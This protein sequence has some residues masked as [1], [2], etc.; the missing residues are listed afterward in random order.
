[1]KRIIAALAAI[2]AVL[3]AV[4]IC[5]L[6]TQQE[7]Q[8][9]LPAGTTAVAQTTAPAETTIPTEPPTEAP[10]EP[11]FVAEKTE[12]SDPEKWGSTWTIMANGEVVE[13]YE[14]E[15]KISFETGDYF[16]LP[17]V[18]SFRG[19][20]YRSDP[21]YGVGDIVSGKIKKLSQMNVYFISDP[22]WMGCGWTGQPLV[23][24][25][26][27]QTR[28][29]MN[30]HDSK[31][32]K[33]GL[34]EVIYAKM[35]GYIHFFDMED[36]SETRDPIYLGMI[37]KGSGSLDP[38]GYPLLYLGSGKEQGNKQPTMFI[39]SL[40]DGSILYE[41]S[42]YDTF[43]T[44]RWYALDSAALVDAETDTL[45]WPGES[46]ILYTFKLNT[47]YD[48]AA[49]TIS[50]DVEEPVKTRYT[51]DYRTKN[52]RNIGY[53]SSAVA[54]KEYLYVADNAGMLQ[55]INL[56]TMELVWTQDIIDDVNATPLF[57]WGEDGNG[58]LYIAPSLDYSNGG[59]YNKLPFCK[60]DARTGEILW[61]YEMECFTYDGVSGG[62]MAS[63]VLG[64]EGTDIEGLII[65]TIARSPK[66][67]DSRI[68]ALNKETGE[69]VWEADTGNYTWSSPVV[70]YNED[71]KSFIFQADATGLCKV[72]EGATGKT[73]D[74]INLQRTIEASPVAYED[75][76]VIG[77][78]S[79]VY[80]F[81][82]Y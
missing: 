28:S 8:T 51:H 57:D 54:V 26:D 35:D 2:A 50:V 37:F 58:Y 41:Q 65:F 27:D 52:A 55:C 53:E 67:W 49:G 66:A 31:K 13:S 43:S 25:W 45:I 33:E 7:V 48:P 16:A 23:V 47:Q 70:L 69:M 12:Q 3:L 42:G 77:T 61:T 4:L 17:G 36:G 60:V 9:Q 15:E 19:G 64:R 72:F 82:I 1:M 68:V 78:R 14:R 5:L 40:I 75:R 74:S 18:A 21:G 22:E 10:T 30:L 20:N 6:L 34:V 24:Q 79:H 44:R 11:P 62:Y 29:I 32:N 71:G 76:V 46:G 73:L 63:P 56:N 81:E 38:R 39:V 59:T 80:L